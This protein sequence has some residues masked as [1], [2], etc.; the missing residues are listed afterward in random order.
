MAANVP[1]AAAQGAPA[2]IAAAEPIFSLTPGQH[3]PTVP[4]NFAKSDDIK[5]CKP[6]SKELGLKVTGRPAQLRNLK[7]TIQD[8]ATEMGWTNSILNVSTSNAQNVPKYNVITYHG[9]LS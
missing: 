1:S 8:S 4:L 6:G 2:A 3:N 9:Q 7:K 5:L